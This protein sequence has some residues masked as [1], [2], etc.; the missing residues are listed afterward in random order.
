M[1]YFQPSVQSSR[2]A[3]DQLIAAQCPVDDSLLMIK[4]ANLLLARVG[5]PASYLC[6]CPAA[7]RWNHRY[8]TNVCLHRRRKLRRNGK[9]LP[10][11]AVCN[12]CTGNTAAGPPSRPLPLAPSLFGQNVEA[13]QITSPVDPLRRKR[14]RA[15]CFHIHVK[16]TAPDVS[17][18]LHYCTR[19]C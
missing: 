11:S 10:Q 18:L 7:L 16:D 4:A 12:C 5:E 14:S 6:C 8:G 2:Y 15:S 17:R 13:A 9:T 19:T 3:Y 1:R